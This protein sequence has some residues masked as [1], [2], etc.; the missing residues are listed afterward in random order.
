[1]R[2]LALSAGLLL[3]GVACR[4]AP[5]NLATFNA[6]PAVSIT[7]PTDGSTYSQGEAV[8]FTGLVSDDA[9]LDNVL[10]E[11]HS[12]IDGVLPWFDSPDEGGNVELATASLSAGPHVVTLRAVDSQDASGESQILVTVEG[13][14]EAPTIEIL[15]PLPG[16]LG[17]QNVPYRYEVKVYDAQTP[18]EQ[19]VVW[20]ETDTSG[21]MCDIT[22]DSTGFGFCEAVNGPGEHVISFYVED[23]DGYRSSAVAVFRLIDPGDVDA[24]GDTFTP[25][26]GDC[27]D[28]N[29][30][31]YPGAPEICDGLDNDCNPATPIDFGTTCYDDDGDGLTEIQGDCNDG[32]AAVYPG[33]TEVPYNG[34]DDDC[35][36]VT[37]DND[38]DGDGHNHPSDCNDQDPAVNPAKPEVCGNAVDENCDG[39]NNSQNAQ[40]CQNFYIDADGDGYAPNG[41]SQQCWCAPGSAPYTATQTGD[42][43]DDNPQV[44]PNQT[45]FF[46]LNRGDGSYDYNCDGNQEKQYRGTTTGCSVGT[47][48]CGIGRAGWE[49]SEPNCGQSGNWLQDCDLDIGALLVGCGAPCAIAC[50]WGAT[51]DCVNCIGSYCPGATKCTKEYGGISVQLCR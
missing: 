26:G 43:K 36:P 33:A 35:N 5:D 29:P 19:L 2:G 6:P 46:S 14:P 11:W 17:P 1:M 48:S 24:D 10:V 9:G 18:L 38:L 42:C 30:G 12:S 15:R 49:G 40:G 37:K 7:A 34:L 44:R 27:N 41:G 31:T 22:P 50:I 16:Q 4:T 21:H 23:T 28:G 8:R 25:N 32:N 13:V 20:A 47:F 39:S 51:T 45:N 3:V